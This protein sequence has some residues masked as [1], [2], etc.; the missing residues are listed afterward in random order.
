MSLQAVFVPA[1][2]NVF[3]NQGYLKSIYAECEGGEKKARDM[4][5]AGNMRQIG[6]GVVGEKIVSYAKEKAESRPPAP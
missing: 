4:Y 2:T 6:I 1:P 5:R 3:M